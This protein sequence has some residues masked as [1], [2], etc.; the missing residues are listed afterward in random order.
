MHKSVPKANKEKIM[1][2]HTSLLEDNNFYFF[3]LRWRTIIHFF[4]PK[5]EDNNSYLVQSESLFVF[6]N[7]IDTK[8]RW[9]IL[10]TY[11]IDILCLAHNMREERKG[12]RMC[13]FHLLYIYSIQRHFHLHKQYLLPYFLTIILFY[14]SLFNETKGLV[15]V[16]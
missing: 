3:F 13:Q 9:E 12:R 6:V 8:V 11:L 10:L 16:S 14:Y 5:L 7:I 1:G 15:L 4:F 2:I